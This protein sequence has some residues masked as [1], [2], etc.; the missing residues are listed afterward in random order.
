[1]LVTEVLYRWRR[2]ASPYHPEEKIKGDLS[3]GVNLGSRQEDALRAIKPAF[4][5]Y[6]ASRS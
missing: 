1:M 5:W 3:R 4:S 2:S 6:N